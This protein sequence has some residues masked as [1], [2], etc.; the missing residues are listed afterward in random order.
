MW[1]FAWLRGVSEKLWYL[2]GWFNR[3]RKHPV[4][5]PNFF[6]YF[7][8]TWLPAKNSVN[9]SLF[10]IIKIAKEKHKQ[11]WRKVKEIELPHRL[12]QRCKKSHMQ[13]A[14]M[15]EASGNGPDQSPREMYTNRTAVLFSFSKCEFRFCCLQCSF[16][17]MTAPSF[18]LD[19]S[20]IYHPEHPHTLNIPCNENHICLF[21][22]NVPSA[23]FPS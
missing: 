13:D 8:S 2:I 22:L 19:L 4:I 5:I 17:S 9:G 10:F 7:S 14:K 3:H 16:S 12:R 1:I 6:K 11:Q 18:A 21:I 15:Q 20:N 23:E